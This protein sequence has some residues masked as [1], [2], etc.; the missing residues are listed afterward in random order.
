MIISAYWVTTKR[1]TG[2]LK[3]SIMVM[4][5]VIILIIIILATITVIHK[6]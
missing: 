3:Q 5:I 6:Q 2:R 4:I 1:G